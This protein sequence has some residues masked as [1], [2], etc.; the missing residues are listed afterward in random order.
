MCFA[1]F[2]GNLVAKFLIKSVA[3]LERGHREE[4]NKYLSNCNS[5]H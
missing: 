5:N 1:R 2:R 4:T 3:T